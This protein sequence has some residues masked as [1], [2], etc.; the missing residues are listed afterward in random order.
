M[1]EPIPP[2]IWLEEIGSTSAEAARRLAEADPG[3]SAAGFWL[4]ARR[5]TA[6]RGRR[7]RPWRAGLGDLTASL[8]LPTPAPP[9]RAAELSF[10]AALAVADLL[11][12]CR[13]TP[14]AALKWPNDA[15]VAGRK[16]AG[17]L[18]EGVVGGVVVGFGVNLAA[19]PPAELLEPAARPAASVAETAPS[20]PTPEAALETLA[21]AW[22]AQF[23]MWRTRGFA[24][25]R[26]AWLARAVGLGAPVVARLPKEEARGVFRDVDL[27][28]ALVLET[29][30]GARR[31]IH[32]AELYFDQSL[33]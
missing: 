11:D 22:A 12:Q 16:I 7:G 30:D 9:P 4:A 28:G 24:P 26:E 21:A 33:G 3:A 32:A 1:S 14:P 18:L 27:S 5:Q 23:E 17:V 31:L 8:A 25:V 15:V 2:R 29:P 6:G 10:V 20:A 19:A 13:V